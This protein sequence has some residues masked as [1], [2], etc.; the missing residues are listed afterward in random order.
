MQYS[1]T[2]YETSN[3]SNQWSYTDYAKQWLKGGLLLAGVALFGSLATLVSSRLKRR[4]DHAV[5]D[6]TKNVSLPDSK[7]VSLPD[8]KAVSLPDGKAVSLPD[9]IGQ[10]MMQSRVIVRKAGQSRN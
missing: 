3:T 9:L 7:V 10:S 2:N 4:S 1:N 6:L 8:D 5:Y